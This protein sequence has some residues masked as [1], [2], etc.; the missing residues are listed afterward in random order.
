MATNAKEECKDHGWWIMAEEAEKPMLWITDHAVLEVR[1][2]SALGKE[3]GEIL[4]ITT[5]GSD[6]LIFHVHTAEDPLLRYKM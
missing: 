3:F 1:H 6:I 5:S 2:W 4:H